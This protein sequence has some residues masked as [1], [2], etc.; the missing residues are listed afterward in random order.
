MRG[1][2]LRGRAEALREDAAEAPEELRRDG[3][4]VRDQ[5]IEFGAANAEDAALFEGR[6]ARAPRAAID[7]RHLAK[8]LPH[9]ELGECIFA[10]MH[11]DMAAEDDKEGIA[12]IALSDDRFS[13]G[14]GP[15]RRDIEHADELLIAHKAEERDAVEE[16]ELEVH[17]LGELD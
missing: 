1:Q 8:M 15:R 12:F 4:L 11:A 9:A 7:Q 10:R 16:L 5:R 14:I 6:D 17:L 2:L 13:L 3:M